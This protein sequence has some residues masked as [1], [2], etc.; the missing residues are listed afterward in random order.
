MFGAQAPG[1]VWH[2]T[3]DHANLKGSEDFQAVPAGSALWN[4]GNG[5][6]VKQPA[7]KKTK[8]GKGNGNTGTGNTGTGTGTTGG[9]N[10][11]G[12]G[13]GGGNGFLPLVSTSPVTDPSAGP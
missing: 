10:G 7:K 13:G 2:M 8:G 11:G 4:A 5:Q 6:A 9:G 3:F 1:T 12:N